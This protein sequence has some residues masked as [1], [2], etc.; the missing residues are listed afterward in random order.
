M[1]SEKLMVPQMGMTWDPGSSPKFLIQKLVTSLV[2][3]RREINVRARAVGGFALP[4]KAARHHA[5]EPDLQ[6]SKKIEAIDVWYLNAP[7]CG[8]RGCQARIPPRLHDQVRRQIA[9]CRT[10]RCVTEN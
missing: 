1:N 5:S 4:I 2:K 10:T 7:C 6:T 8:L 9:E 3:I